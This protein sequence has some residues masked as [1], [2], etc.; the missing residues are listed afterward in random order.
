MLKEII[1]ILKMSSFGIKTRNN[2]FL[3]PKRALWIVIFYLQ[4]ITFCMKNSRKES[5]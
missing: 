1:H 5:S 2:M 4:K 3:K